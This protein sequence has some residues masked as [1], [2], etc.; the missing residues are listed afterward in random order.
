MD[1][2]GGLQLSTVTRTRTIPLACDSKLSPPINTNTGREV[3]TYTAGFQAKVS[4][5]EQIANTCSSVSN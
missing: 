1:A 3:A 5:A 2:G 4:T